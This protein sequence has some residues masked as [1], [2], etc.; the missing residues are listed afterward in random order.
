[1]S[2]RETNAK[3]NGS[4]QLKKMNNSNTPA[5]SGMT[6]G[7]SGVVGSGFFHPKSKYYIR[8]VAYYLCRKNNPR[9]HGTDRR[10]TQLPAGVPALLK[11]IL[12]LHK[13]D[14]KTGRS[15]IQDLMDGDMFIRI[16]RG[17]ILMK[18]RITKSQYKQAIAILEQNEIVERKVERDFHG[19]ALF[20][21]CNMSK[22]NDLF[23]NIPKLRP[24]SLEERDAKERQNPSHPTRDEES[25]NTPVV[26]A[27]SQP[28]AILPGISR[29]ENRPALGFGSQKPI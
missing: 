15:P 21:K 11:L 20:L 19:S 27:V 2:E 5:S 6:V 29:S 24:I 18:T 7:Q 10:K 23:A 13:R 17:E 28:D 22:L 16:S 26:D 14:V 12:D 3:I 1:V 4:I 9:F 8:D 25:I